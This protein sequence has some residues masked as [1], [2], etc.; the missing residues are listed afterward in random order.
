MDNPHSSFYEQ[1]MLNPIQGLNCL[2]PLTAAKATLVNSL[3]FVVT[4]NLW[5]HKKNVMSRP[6]GSTIF[7]PAVTFLGSAANA[8]NWLYIKFRILFS[9]NENFNLSRFHIV[10]DKWEISFF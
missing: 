2:H 5:T 7:I 4:R 8:L 3:L 10:Y 1:E 9:L 6:M